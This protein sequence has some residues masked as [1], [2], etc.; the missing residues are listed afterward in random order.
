MSRQRSQERRSFGESARNLIRA[1]GAGL[2]IGL[3]IL[4]TQE[5]WANGF[6]LHPLKIALLLGVAFV[7][8]VGYNAASGFRAD[9][10][11]LDVLI[12]S[13][14]AMGLGI[15]VALVVLVLFGRIEPDMGLREI[16]GKVSLEAI[17]VAF[18]AS[19]ARSQLASSDDEPDEGSEGGDV[20]GSAEGQT[21]PAHRLFVAA[22]GALLFALNVAPTDEVVVLGTRAGWPLLIAVMVV[23]LLVTLALVFYADFRGGRDPHPGDSP[24]DHPVSETLAA[25]AISL[26]IALGLLW[27][28]DRTEGV[29]LPAILGMTVML[30][31]AASLGAAVGRLLLGGGE[32]GDGAVKATD[33]N[34]GKRDENA[35]AEVGS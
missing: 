13:I 15:L 19:L 2:L 34:G 32:S 22:G 27:A 20:D 24:M 10:S 29:A 5:I 25:Y 33:G 31:V 9:S 12:D 3:P 1:V 11:V 18:G 8:V 17:P 4:F 30:G 28:F 16:A 6:V 14:E 23:S 35:Q 26:G 7:V 21:G